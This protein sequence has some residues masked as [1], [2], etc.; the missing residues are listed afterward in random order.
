MKVSEDLS[1]P[2]TKNILGCTLYYKT[3]IHPKQKMS[4]YPFEHGSLLLKLYLESGC[5]YKILQ[6]MHC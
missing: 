2:H 1:L 4:E 5:L 3:N 6:D